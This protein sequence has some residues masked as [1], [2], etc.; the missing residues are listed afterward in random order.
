VQINSNYASTNT[1]NTGQTANNITVN[2]SGTYNLRVR[3]NNGCESA[4][5]DVIVKVNPL[6]A[7]PYIDPERATIF[8]NGDFTILAASNAFQYNWNTG[9][10]TRRINVVNSGTYSLSI[11]DVNGCKSPSSSG[12]VVKVN[13]LPAAPVI[14]ASKMPAEVCQGEAVT[15]SSNNQSNYAWNGG[16]NTQSITVNLPGTYSVRSLDANGC[17]QSIASK[18]THYGFGCYYYL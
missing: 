5:N 2:K 12:L 7:P 3:D 17:Y 11:T 9:E 16:Q 1:W 6:P 10:T 14:S 15:I 18:T 13:P 8:C 4:S